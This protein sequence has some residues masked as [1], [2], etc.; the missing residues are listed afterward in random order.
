MLKR[1]FI[2][3]SEEKEKIGFEYKKKDMKGISGK[4]VYRR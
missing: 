1:S 4:R 3:T 2:I